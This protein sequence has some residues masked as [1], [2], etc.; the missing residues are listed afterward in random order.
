MHPGLMIPAQR[1]KMGT[2]ID[3][4]MNTDLEDIAAFISFAEIPDLYDLTALVAVLSV[5]YSETPGRVKLKVL[6]API[7]LSTPT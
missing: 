6:P 5:G 2:Q 3:T 4:Q 1:G 7:S